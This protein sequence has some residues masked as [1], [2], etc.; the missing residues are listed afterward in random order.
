MGY[1]AK[2]IM[3]PFER[4]PS[5]ISNRLS[6]TMHKAASL[7]MEG[8]TLSLPLHAHSKHLGEGKF[9][10]DREY[11]KNVPYKQKIIFHLASSDKMSQFFSWR[12]D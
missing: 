7:R 9:C 5:K 6:K 8:M 10:L 11:S 3:V 1:H 4:S 12:E 2:N